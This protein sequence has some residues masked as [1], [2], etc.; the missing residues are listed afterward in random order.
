[1]LNLILLNS[2]ILLHFAFIVFVVL[3]A[4]LVMKWRWLLLPHMT[5]VGW[6]IYIEVSHGICPL[7]HYEMY[8]RQ[9]ANIAGYPGGFIEHYLYPIIYPAGLTA[10]IQITLAIAVVLINLLLYSGLIWRYLRSR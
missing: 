4:L 1:M 2:V 7:T 5:A 8:F 10:D 3:G 9:Q 6:G